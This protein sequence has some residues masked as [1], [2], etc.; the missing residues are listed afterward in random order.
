MSHAEELDRIYATLPSIEC[1]RLCQRSCGPLLMAQAEH[2]RIKDHLG[3]AFKRVQP[4]DLACPM[5]DPMGNCSIYRVRPAICRLYGL[6]EMLRCEH[7]CEPER[8]LSEDEARLLLRRISRLTDKSGRLVS[9]VGPWLRQPDE[10][11]DGH[12]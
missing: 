3:P 7:G 10:D 5:L 11:T 6:T 2:D 1:K 8:W 4:Q 12:L 9:V